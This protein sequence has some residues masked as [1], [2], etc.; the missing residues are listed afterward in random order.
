MA[1]NL[2]SEFDGWKIKHVFKKRGQLT[3]QIQARY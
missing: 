2:K 3:D 1:E